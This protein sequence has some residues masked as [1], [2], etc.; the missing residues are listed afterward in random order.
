MNDKV[1]KITKK[2]NEEKKKRKRKK[3]KTKEYK[4][5]DN[6]LYRVFMKENNGPGPLKNMFQ[7]PTIYK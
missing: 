2:K 5:V 1:R 6:K 4:G 7:T 3:I